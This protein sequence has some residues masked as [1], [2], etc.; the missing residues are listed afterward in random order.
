MIVIDSSALIEFLLATPRGL[1]VAAR[2]TG[3]GETLHAPHLID[4]ELL[5]TMRKLERQGLRTATARLFL[6]CPSV[7]IV[8]YPH[9]PLWT[10]VWRLR[11][12]LTTYDASYVALAESL[13]APLVT[14]DAR[15]AAAPG[16]S[17]NVEVY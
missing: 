2:I 5:S 1:H 8:R 17:A 7:A 6:L 15:I 16:H 3:P 11:S 12:N 14:C 10:R 4:L 13:P 9:V